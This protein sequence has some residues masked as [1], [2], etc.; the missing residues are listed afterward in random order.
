M[1]FSKIKY[2]A[3]ICCTCSSSH[4]KTKYDKVIE[5]IFFFS[6]S[7]YFLSSFCENVLLLLLWITLR[8]RCEVK[9]NI[10]R[11]NLHTFVW[12][13]NLLKSFKIHAE[14]RSDN[15]NLFVK[16]DAFA[17]FNTLCYLRKT[18]RWFEKYFLRILRDRFRIAR[19]IKKK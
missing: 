5:C 19:W 16:S 13:R 7:P 6:V 11:L 8:F 1:C 3:N 18:L 14:F 17:F 12:M 15:W 10:F 4:Q 2:S 9:F